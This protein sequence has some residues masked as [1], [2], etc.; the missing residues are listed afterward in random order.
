V[1]AEYLQLQNGSGKPVSLRWNDISDG[2]WGIGD[3]YSGALTLEDVFRNLG[4]R[5]MGDLVVDSHEL[6][7]RFVE[8]SR[9]VAAKPPRAVELSRKDRHRVDS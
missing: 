3:M 8:I 9:K 2:V 4:L 1:R 7:E 5:M 6:A